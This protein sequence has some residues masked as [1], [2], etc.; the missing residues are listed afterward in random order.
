MGMTGLVIC[1]GNPGR[2]DDGVAHRVA[3][4]LNEP[5]APDLPCQARVLALHQ[6]DIALATDVS[7]AAGVVFVDAE[8]RT[9]PAAR[10]EPLE[11]GPGG[12]SVH[13]IDPSGLLGLAQALYGRAPKAALVTVAGP[14]MAHGEGLSATAEAAS[15]EAASL[16]RDTL[17]SVCEGSGT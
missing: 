6:L 11:A 4:R 8:R 9:E 16:V 7:Q 13:S 5:T 10:V 2:R 12:R 15:E 14:E 17:R 3:E 1:I